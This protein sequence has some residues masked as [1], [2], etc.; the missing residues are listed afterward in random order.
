LADQ[1]RDRVR[2]LKEVL[3]DPPPVTALVPAADGSVTLEARYWLEY[4]QHDPVS[5]R[6]AV[7][8]QVHEAIHAA[9]AKPVSR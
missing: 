3:S 7:S 1:V 6:N 4:R 8:Q 9:T 2:S 5:V